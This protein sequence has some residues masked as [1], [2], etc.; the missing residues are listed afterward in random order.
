MSINSPFP[1]PVILIEDDDDL[2]E[3]IGVTLRINK[4]NFFTHQKAETVIPILEPG[5]QAIIVTDYKLPGMNGI[6]LLKKALE[7]SPDLP[8]IVMTAFADAKLAVEALKAGAR[9]FLIKPF[10]P[11]QLVE[12]IRRYQPQSPNEITPSVQPQSGFKA[13]LKASGTEIKGQAGKS[14]IAVDPAMLTTLSRAERVA[15]TTTSVLITGESGVGKEVIAKYIH[16]HSTRAHGPYIALNCAAIPE[17]LLES[18]LFGHEKGSF[19]GASK[20]QVGKFEQANGGTLFLDEIGE[21]PAQL[22]AKLLRVLQDQMV[23]KLGSTELVPVDVRIISATNRNLLQRVQEGQ[24]RQDLYFRLAV[25]PVHIPELSMR[26]QDILPLAEFFLERYSK[27]VNRENMFL[28]DSAQQA[29][30]DHHWPGNVRELENTI[31]RAVLMTDDTQ[32]SEAHLELNA[33]N[34]HELINQGQQAV[35]AGKIAHDSLGEKIPATHFSEQKTDSGTDI[36]SYSSES[37][38]DMESVER[39]HILKVLRQVAG[40]QEKAVEILGITGK[41]L[42]IKLKI[43]KDAGLIE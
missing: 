41:A 39:E 21:M 16:D 22:Q 27:N 2:R 10:V 12:T 7:I 13:N 18:I 34:E 8:V 15:P 28:S 35:K 33:T 31:Q 43:Y 42:K 23:E 32:V 11:D 4:I 6:E 17:S 25:F 24:F 37:L 1:C 14:L 5:M 36:A 40:N 20:T 3:A 9:D 38:S 30:L 26:P 29:L 19:T